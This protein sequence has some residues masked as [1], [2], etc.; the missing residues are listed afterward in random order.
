MTQLPRRPVLLTIIAPR[1]ARPPGFELEMAAVAQILPQPVRCAG[2]MIPMR[3]VTRG[4]LPFHVSSYW[5]EPVMVKLNAFSA[6]SK[7]QPNMLPI[8]SA[9]VSKL[10]PMRLTIT[11][12]SAALGGGMLDSART[13]GKQL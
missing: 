4:T 9:L 13:R 2:M 1:I 12:V 8:A 6:S 7:S 10:P 5:Q 3:G 11:L